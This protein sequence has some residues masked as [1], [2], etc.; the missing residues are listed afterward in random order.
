MKSILICLISK[1]SNYFNNE[2]DHV[3]EDE[4]S[5]NEADI[6]AQEILN[7]SAKISQT[8]ICQNES[9]SYNQRQIEREKKK[10]EEQEIL[11]YAAM[12]EKHARERDYMEQLG[13]DPDDY[14]Q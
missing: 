6:I 7:N 14:E 13:I 3:I 11:L 9:P 8:L 2:I 10:R 12:C 1:L 5:L 4:G